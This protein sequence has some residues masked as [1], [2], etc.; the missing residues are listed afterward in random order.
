VIKSSLPFAFPHNHGSPNSLTKKDQPDVGLLSQWSDIETPILSI[1]EGHSLFLV[2]QTCTTK[3][4]PYG[5]L[6]LAGA[7]QGFHVPPNKYV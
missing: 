1:T 2:S 6:S 5:L 3:G 7:V 4:P